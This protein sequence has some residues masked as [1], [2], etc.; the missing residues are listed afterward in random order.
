MPIHRRKWWIKKLNEVAE[1]RKN[2]QEQVV[3]MPSQAS[4]G[5]RSMRAREVGR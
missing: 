4:A 1:E 2:Q 5:Q 3:R